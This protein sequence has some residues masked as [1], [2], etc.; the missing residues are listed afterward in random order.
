MRILTTISLTLLLTA[1]ENTL[2]RNEVDLNITIHEDRLIY[3]GIVGAG[4]NL[5]LVKNGLIKQQCQ[6]MGHSIET[7]QTKQHSDGTIGVHAVCS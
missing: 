6:K 5:D 7:F 3:T 4:T 1:C 2:D